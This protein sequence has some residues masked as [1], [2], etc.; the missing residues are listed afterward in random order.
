MKNLRIFS[1]IFTVSA[2]LGG[3]ASLDFQ[4]MS[5]GSGLPETALQNNC[6]SITC[7]YDELKDRVQ[8]SANDMNILLALNGGET[9][10]IQYTWVSGSEY[11]SVDVFLTSLYGSW[12]FVEEAEIYVGKKMVAK[13]SGQVDRIIGAYNEIA[14]EVEKTEMI[15]GVIPV[16]V[17][18]E[19]AAANHE[20]V[21][22]RFYGKNGYEDKKL[23]RK[24]KLIQ[25]VN[26][27][28]SA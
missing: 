19:I 12:S 6:K 22:I 1:A 28:K 3:C 24:H 20:E 25:V 13:V 11:I 16:Q 4:Q 21:T 18:E 2:M 23:P 17:A 7:S 14:G 5:A 26:L 9:R 27:A 8:V 15:S 10:T